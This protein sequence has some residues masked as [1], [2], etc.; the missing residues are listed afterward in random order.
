[1][2]WEA[3]LG[4]LV[5]RLQ[6]GVLHLHLHTNQFKAATCLTLPRCKLPTAC[7]VTVYTY[8]TQVHPTPLLS[9]VWMQK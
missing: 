1:M 6:S 3:T 5:K 2:T 8:P 4:E 9:L 7:L